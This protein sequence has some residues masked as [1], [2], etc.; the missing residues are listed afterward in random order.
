MPKKEALL[1]MKFS[2]LRLHKRHAIDKQL[3]LLRQTRS[4]F[5]R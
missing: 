2:S 1:L 5:W 4:M 3:L